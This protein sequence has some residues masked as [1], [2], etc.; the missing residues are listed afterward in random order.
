MD[1]SLKS[2]LDKQIQ[3]TIENLEKNNISVIYTESKKQVAAKV[4]ELLKD[5]ETIACGGSMSLLEC[6][7]MDLIRSGRYNFL[8]RYAKGLSADQIEEIHRRS[9]MADTYITGTNAITENGDLYNV[10]GRG[11]RV[12]AMIY[13]PK[14]VIVV[15]GINKLVKD[16][17]GAVERVRRI[18]GPANAT[19]LGLNTP[20]VKTGFCI[21]CRSDERICS[22]YTVFGHQRIKDRIKVIL[23][24]ESLGY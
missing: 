13:G 14:S 19:R 15:A 1:S 22:V 23:V 3:K 6:G 4:S 8:D 9:F 21:Q 16:I 7:V 5:G 2:V 17:D 10:D 18:A 20:C 11:N 12:A 24:G